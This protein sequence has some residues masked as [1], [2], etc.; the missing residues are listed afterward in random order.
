MLLPFFQEELLEVGCD[1]AGRGCL[2]GPVFA[3]AV[4]LPK[5]FHHPLLN[6][7]KQL[8]ETQRKQLR[9][10]IEAQALA[11]AVAQVDH[12]EIDR[13]NIL[14]ASF[15]AMHRALDSLKTRPEF[16]LVDGNRFKKYQDLPHQCIVK[17]DGKYFS[18]AAA[19]IL[20]K[21]Y[22]DDFMEQIAVQ[23][24]QYD[25]SSNKGYP[26]IKHREA[27]LAHGFSP[28]HRRSFKVTDPQLTLFQ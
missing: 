12:E 22:R 25:W 18:I 16:I 3:A 15:L 14:Q 20:A 7:S 17:G 8:N 23:Y 4:I 24:P 2:A 26:T 9:V 6:D 27:V 11:F 1:E 10:E 13:I 19:S 28:Y 21:T 5:D